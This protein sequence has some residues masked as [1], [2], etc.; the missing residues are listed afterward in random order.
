MKDYYRNT[1][2]CISEY[3]RII[4]KILTCEQELTDKEE[5]R[6]DNHCIYLAHA[7][8]KDAGPGDK[9]REEMRKMCTVILDVLD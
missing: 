5:E 3:N 8:I 7:L 2:A 4:N 1:R 6:L 9:T